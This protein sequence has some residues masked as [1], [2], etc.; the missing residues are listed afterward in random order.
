MCRDSV[1]L[2]E[3]LV[4]FSTLYY[5]RVYLKGALQHMHCCAEDVCPPLCSSIQFV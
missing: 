5:R 1:G 3:D 4:L 2:W